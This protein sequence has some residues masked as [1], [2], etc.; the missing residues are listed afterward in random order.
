MTAPGPTRRRAPIAASVATT[1]LAMLALGVLGAAPTGAAAPSTPAKCALTPSDAGDP[2][3]RPNA[4]VRSSVGSGFMLTGIVRCGID[5]API[6]RARVEFW[7]RGPD[8][9][10]DDAHRGTVIADAGGRYRIQSNFPGG[11]EF[12]PHIH[13][14]IEVAGFRP[15]VTVCFPQGGSQ[16]GAMDLVLEP[17]L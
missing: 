6:P 9:Q 12:R 17:E 7:L 8:G 11:T 4:P 16:A 10:Y 1:A 14:R 3:Y 5:C 13:L 15:L 2:A